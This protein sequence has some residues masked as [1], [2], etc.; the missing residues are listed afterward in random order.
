MHIMIILLLLPV[1]G[2]ILFFVLPFSQALPSYLLVLAFSAFFYVLMFRAMRKSRQKSLFEMVGETAEALDWKDGR[3]QVLCLGAIWEARS[4]TGRSFPRDA[5]LRVTGVEGLTL[6]V[7][8]AGDDQ[9]GAGPQERPD[10]V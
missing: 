10:R 6:V 7:K 1:L 4:E 2:L 8:A 9:A 5:K 3:G